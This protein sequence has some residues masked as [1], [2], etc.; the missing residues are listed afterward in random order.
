MPLITA[1]LAEA[2]AAVVMKAMRV[3]ASDSGRGL[4]RRVRLFA[5]FSG[6]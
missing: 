4:K 6:R 1:S 2:D 3:G 5:A